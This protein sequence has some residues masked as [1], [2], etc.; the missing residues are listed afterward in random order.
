[1][2]RWLAMGGVWMLIAALAVTATAQSKAAAGPNAS[3]TVQ[4][5]E[6]SSAAAPHMDKRL[7][8]MSR[9]LKPFQ[10]QYN[11]FVLLT[12]RDFNLA[13]GASGTVALPGDKTFGLQ[14]TGFTEGKVRRVR[15]SVQMPHTRMKRSVA[16]GG[17]TLDVVRN[18]AKLTIVSTLVR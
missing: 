6:A 14:F 10:G 12:A 2:M 17:Q 13:A 15:Y 11:H 4:V 8:G 9:H 18:G 7:E 1:M 5:I 3:F 16:P